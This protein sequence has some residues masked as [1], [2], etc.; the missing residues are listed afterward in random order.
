MSAPLDLYH[1]NLNR[2]SA[3]QESTEMLERAGVDREV[4]EW[5]WEQLDRIDGGYHYEIEVLKSDKYEHFHV[6]PLDVG[7]Y[8]RLETGDAGK[9]IAE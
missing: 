8:S 7:K 3:Q 1:L 9:S 4:I 5:F 2:P 6:F